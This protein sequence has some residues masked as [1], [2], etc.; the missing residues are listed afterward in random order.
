MVKNM[1]SIWMPC[2]LR[3]S[4][5]S[6]QTKSRH[7]YCAGS[8]TVPV[9]LPFSDN[10]SR[11]ERILWFKFPAGGWL[12]VPSTLVDNPLIRTDWDGLI[13]AAALRDTVAAPKTRRRTMDYVTRCQA[14]H[15]SIHYPRI[16][17]Q[18]ARKWN[19]RILSYLKMTSWNGRRNGTLILQAQ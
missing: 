8:I 16:L 1:T 14:K 13:Q 7:S 15:L 9:R 6:R 18:P 3:R 19:H 12:T 11:Y 2:V 5:R 17:Y 4:A 10:I